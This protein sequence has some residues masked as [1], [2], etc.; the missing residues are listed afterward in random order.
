MRGVKLPADMIEVTKTFKKV[1]AKKDL[2]ILWGAL[3]KCYGTPELAKQVR[4][5]WRVKALPAPPVHVA[6]PSTLWRACMLSGMANPW[7]SPPLSP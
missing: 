6:R 2:E 1:Y 4:R 5:H 3:L 7:P